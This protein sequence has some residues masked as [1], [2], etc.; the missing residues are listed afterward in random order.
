MIIDG[1]AK[2]ALIDNDNVSWVAHIPIRLSLP[3]PALPVP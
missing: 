3:A 1:K 2:C